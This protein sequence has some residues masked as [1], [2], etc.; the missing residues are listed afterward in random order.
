MKDTKYW[1]MNIDL[2]LTARVE[3]MRERLKAKIAKP[4]FT[5]IV[6]RGLKLWLVEM[7]EAL[8]RLK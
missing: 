4:T 3:E 2:E 7:E 5:G 6:E 8:T 1:G